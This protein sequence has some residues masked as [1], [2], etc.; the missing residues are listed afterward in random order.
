MEL[1]RIVARAAVVALF[2]ALSVGCVAEIEPDAEEGQV[3]EADLGE[4]EQALL[5]DILCAT[6]FS[7]TD[8]KIA[9]CDLVAGE[10]C[11]HT[12]PDAS[13]GSDFA[14]SEA[15][16]PYMNLH[17]HQGD[18]VDTGNYPIQVQAFAYPWVTNAPTTKTTCERWR[19]ELAAYYYDNNGDYSVKAGTAVK[20]GV[21]NGSSCHLDMPMISYTLNCLP[22]GCKTTPVVSARA[23][24]GNPYG[25]P[26]VQRVVL[27]AYRTN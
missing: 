9:S 8:Y 10:F 1:S 11:S 5:G 20:S 24:I 16:Q 14:S 26:L 22:T 17:Y 27:G 25:L 18:W 6:N 19:V 21:W 12:T 15:C 7:T 23:Y 4:A 13:Y 2:P 3:E